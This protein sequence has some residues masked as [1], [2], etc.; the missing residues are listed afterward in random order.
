MQF[1]PPNIS[2]EDWDALFLQRCQ[3][4][5]NGQQCELQIGH[6]GECHRAVVH[7]KPYLVKK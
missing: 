6:A 7:T 3:S 5:V 4:L 1:G 2:Q